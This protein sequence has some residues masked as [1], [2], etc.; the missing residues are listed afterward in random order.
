VRALSLAALLAGCSFSAEQGGTGYVCERDDQ[1]PAGQLCDDGR[2]ARRADAS[3]GPDATPLPWWDLDWGKRRRLQIRNPGP[4]EL[5][6]GFQL[7]LVIDIETT[8]GDA[9]RAAIRV[10]HHDGSAW[11]ELD[12]TIEPM[13]DG[14]E[15]IWFGLPAALDAEGELELW[16]YNDNP[17]AEEAPSDPEALFDDYYA[18]ISDLAMSDWVVAGPLTVEGNLVRLDNG[19][20]VRSASPRPVDRAVDFEIRVSDTATRFW[21]GL[22]R[23]TPDVN[24]EPPWILWIRRETMATSEIAPEYLPPGGETSDAWRGTPA[25]IGADRRL[26]TVERLA[27]RVVY[28]QD[29][30][31]VAADHDHMLQSEHTAPMYL[32]LSNEGASSFWVASIK[33][34]RAAYPPPSLTLGEPEAL[35]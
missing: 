6:A 20:D 1:C 22:Q 3:P 13:H 35:P 30:E 27:D 7:A 28:R 12:R 8:L 33:V 16:I 11:V 34:R 2:C 26:Y 31:L 21:F 14:I 25:T 4:N 24:P 19:A 17:E 32:R 9:R 15:A 23:E 29:L 10:L 5:E 18:T